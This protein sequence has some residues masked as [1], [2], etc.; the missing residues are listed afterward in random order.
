MSQLIVIER[1]KKTRSNAE[2]MRDLIDSYT[3]V[4]C[5]AAIELKTKSMLSEARK[6]QI[7]NEGKMMA[8]VDEFE[9]EQKELRKEFKVDEN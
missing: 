5:K 1:R 7:I 8:G 4:F 9:K 3:H 2:T 6:T